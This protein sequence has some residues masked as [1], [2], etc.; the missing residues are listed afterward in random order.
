MENKPLGKVLISIY[1]L[2]G[3]I[4]GAFLAFSALVLAGVPEV[5]GIMMALALVTGAL[6]IG[7]L[8][9]AYGLWTDQEWAHKLTFAV[10]SASIPLTII[11]HLMLNEQGVSRTAPEMAYTTA[12][13]IVSF[14][15]LWYVKQDKKKAKSEAVA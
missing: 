7:L 10:Y 4:A 11:S 6:S 5:V 13:I 1:S 15:I 12:S 8:A 9:S 2:L 14:I 3:G